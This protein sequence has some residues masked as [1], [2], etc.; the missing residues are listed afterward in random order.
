[1]RGCGVGV[2]GIG[3]PN[4]TLDWV[5]AELRSR[6]LLPSVEESPGPLELL[7]R[8][9]RGVPLA[10]ARKR[11]VAEP[12]GPHEPEDLLSVR[13]V[14][15]MFGVCEK[16]VRKMIGD[17]ELPSVLV[18]GAVRIQARDVDRWVSARKEGR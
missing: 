7:D 17:G 6:G 18:R 8:F 10:G 11:R 16:T 13:R 4:L 12:V 9:V 14:A 15:R 2:P 5:V 3:I 1:M